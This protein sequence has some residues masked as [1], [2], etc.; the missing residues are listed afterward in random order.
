MTLSSPVSRHRDWLFAIFLVTATFIAYYPAWH[1]GYFWDEYCVP[2]DPK[3]MGHY[4]LHGLYNIWFHQTRQ[5]YPLTYTML[6]GEYHIWGLNTTGF[7]L[8]NIFLHSLNGILVWIVLRR[9]KV[10]GAWLAGAV[11]AL[12]PVNVESAAWIAE[13]K[14][15]LSCFLYLCAIMTAFKFWLPE[16]TAAPGSTPV[17]RLKDWKFFWL[18]FV[19]YLFAMLAKT[20]TIPLPAV[21]LLLVWWKRGKIIKA[22]VYPLLLFFAAAMAMGLIT[23]HYEQRL[24][25]EGKEFQIS[26]VDRCLVAGRNFWFYLE[27]I[28]W[29]HPL[30]FVYPRWKIAPSPMLAWLSLLAFIP[31]LAVLW[32][33]RHSWGRTVFVA[34]AYFAGLLFFVLGFFNVFY[35]T[36]SF[37]ADHFQYLAMIGPLALTCAG[38]ALIF[39]RLG[40]VQ[41]VLAPPLAACL[42]A[43]LGVL[44]WIQ[45]HN[46]ADAQ[47]LWTSVVAKNPNVFQA[48]TNLGDLL[49]AEG[50]VDAAIEQ[51]EMSVALNPDAENYDQLGNVYLQTGNVKKAFDA[52]KKAIKVEPDNGL[53]YTDMGNLYLQTRQ[54]DAA[55][56]CF[57]KALRID[58]D[59]PVAWYDLG[60]TYIQKGQLDLAI[61][62]WQKA[63]TIEPDYAPAHGNLGNALLMKGR[64]AE[65]IQHW[66]SALAIEPNLSAQVNLAWVL[67]TCPQES[68]RD[69]TDA[70]GLAE[71]ANQMTGG[72]NPVVLRTLAAAYAE[73]GQF[74]FAVATAQ[75]ALQTAALQGNKELAATVQQQLKFYQN[76]QPFRDTTTMRQ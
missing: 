61:N 47:A 2:H 63:V 24:G 37:A 20:T 48:H 6:W 71:Q 76:N 44:T 31:V 66:R 57:Q 28:F 30:I 49:L 17:E 23:H 58:S 68:L 67:A 42:F 8:M 27:K 59:I 46:Y 10:P 21:I 12:H 1:G 33:A 60:N 22:D 19:L 7:H 5:Y 32:L 73:N 41:F 39:R 29:P 72:Q 9:L 13:R 36:Y 64:I 3:D 43:V 69:G 62:A 35:F 14:N 53:A 40:N 11:F 55:I 52:F 65:A 56:E 51:Y 15:T 75:Q 34:L 50:K 45:C 54:A 74:S 26:L 18:T 70:V 25:A 38:I 4:T 16:E